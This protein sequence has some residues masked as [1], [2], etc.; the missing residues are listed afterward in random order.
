MKIRPKL[1]LAKYS[2]TELETYGQ[3][4]V[5]R[6][7][8]NGDFPS[9]QPT[10]ILLKDTLIRFGTAISILNGNKAD[11]ATKNQLQVEVEQLLTLTVIF[12]VIDAG[13]DMAKFLRSGFAVRN[14]GSLM[15]AL[16]EPQQFDF[17][18]SN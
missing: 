14:P 8:N 17:A 5:T 6:I 1:Q 16:P 11:T 18:L 3:D 4:K 7:G 15:G 2:A 13:E 12:C 10:I 9:A